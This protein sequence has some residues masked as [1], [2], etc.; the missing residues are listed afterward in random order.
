MATA[1]PNSSRLYSEGKNWM[2]KWWTRTYWVPLF[3]PSNVLKQPYCNVLVVHGVPEARLVR[4]STIME[5]ERAPRRWGLLEYLL[6]RK[7]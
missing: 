1:G 5:M 6:R 2:E 4:V 3:N 7:I